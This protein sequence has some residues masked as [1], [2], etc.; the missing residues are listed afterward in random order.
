ME[1]HRAIAATGETQGTRQAML[2]FLS[3]QHHEPTD[4][5]PKRVRFANPFG[6]AS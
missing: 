6:V 3:A 1:Q 4:T 5:N 2:P